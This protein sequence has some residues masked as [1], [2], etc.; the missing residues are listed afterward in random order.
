MKMENLTAETARNFFGVLGEL[1]G[2]RYPVSV[3]RK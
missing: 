2:L 3:N 1:L